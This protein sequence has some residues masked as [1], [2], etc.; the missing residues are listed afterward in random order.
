MKDGYEGVPL[1][2]LQFWTS[3]NQVPATAPDGNTIY[4]DEGICELLLA[5]WGKG[6]E[7]VYS[8]SGGHENISRALEDKT[9][10]G[11]IFF[12]TEE[13]ATRFIRTVTKVFPVRKNP[14]YLEQSG[15]LQNKVVRFHWDMVPL[16]LKVF[17]ADNAKQ[18]FE[19]SPA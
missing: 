7:T 5:L 14:Y 1:R 17:A 6:Y 18:I 19:T 16:F 10:E 11:Y 4:V 12:E 9:G 8:C 15:G 3:H 2:D 13:M